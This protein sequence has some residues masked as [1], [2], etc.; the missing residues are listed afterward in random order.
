MSE[1]SEFFVGDHHLAGV[2]PKTLRDGHYSHEHQ[3]D[4]SGLFGLP[5]VAAWRSL[6]PSFESSYSEFVRKIAASFTSTTGYRHQTSESKND[7]DN[8]EAHIFPFADLHVT[9]VTFRTLLDPKPADSD[10]L[11]RFCASVV[12]NA[13]KRDGW[14]KDAKLKLKPKEIRVFK[15]NAIILFE[16]STGK[17]AAMRACVKEEMEATDSTEFDSELTWFVPNIIHSTV[18]RFW[19]SPSNPELVKQVFEDSSLINVLPSEIEVDANATLACE[20][21]PCMHISDDDFHVAWRGK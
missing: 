11:K 18:I 15:K 7:E 1:A 14:P 20:D 16:E 10:R 5:L 19:K 6:P 21:I 4:E 17:F 13:S 9:L 3:A 12:E 2:D 8:P